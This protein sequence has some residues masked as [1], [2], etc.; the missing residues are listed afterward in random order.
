MRVRQKGGAMTIAPTSVQPRPEHHRSRW[1][2]VA[3]L[4]FLLGGLTVALLYQF[5]VFGSSS[6]SSANGSGIA[7]AQTRE[8]AAFNRVELAGGNNVVIRVGEKQSVV[9]KADDNLLDR[10]T[11]RVESGALVIGNTSGSLT[12]DTPMSVE[13]NVPSLNAVA[14]TGAGNVLVTGIETNSLTVSLSGSGNLLGSGT[15]TSLEITVSGYGNARFTNVAA[16]NVHAVMSGSGA[17]F[18]TAT[19][20]LDASV[21]GSGTITYAGNPQHVTQSI[22]GS[23]A[24]TATP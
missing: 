18:V 6:S 2:L 14:L 24:I 11:T 16:D 3:I 5:D 1:V 23:G 21:P 4:A 8:V 7:A 15:A 19:K 12:S 10:V 22:T 13:V 17:I 9:V 20:S